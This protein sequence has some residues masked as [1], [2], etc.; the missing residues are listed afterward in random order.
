MTGPT[1]FLDGLVGSLTAVMTPRLRSRTRWSRWAEARRRRAW[2]RAGTARRR[3]SAWPG[4]PCRAGEPRGC[5]PSWR[6]RPR[7]L[8]PR[9]CRCRRGRASARSRPGSWTRSE[10]APS[11][12][13]L[14]FGGLV[15]LDPGVAVGVV[16]A[17]AD[18]AEA[19]VL[20]HAAE[21]RR[22]DLPG[23][24]PVD[25]RH[26]ALITLGLLLEDP[27]VD[28]GA[29]V[30][31]AAVVL[32]R[33]VDQVLERRPH[34]GDVR[35]V[36]DDREG[37]GDGLVALALLQVVDDDVPALPE[38]VVPAGVL[39]LQPVPLVGPDAGHGV[40]PQGRPP[41]PQAELLAVVVLV[42][43]TEEDVPVPRLVEA[44]LLQRAGELVDDPLLH[45][46][47][48]RPLSVLEGHVVVHGQAG[49]DR[50]ELPRPPEGDVD[51]VL[52]LLLLA[53]L[54]HGL[55]DGRADLGVAGLVGLDALDQLGEGEV[56][57]PG[58]VGRQTDELQVRVPRLEGEV[59]HDRRGQG[60]A[61][62]EHVVEGVAGGGG[63]P[64]LGA[65]AD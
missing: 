44:E 5:Q 33:E 18:D 41:R 40:E 32:E 60:I 53:G 25:D 56:A 50:E 54:D 4:S 7:R 31:Q 64:R 49:Q 17:L 61:G 13:R 46:L 24:E 2:R 62:H 42:Q 57:G 48:E 19:H 11:L 45:E 59:G 23:Q 47:L 63:A 6:R 12:P 14:P 15:L 16:A 9:C 3:P 10:T 55:Q 30:V 28:L 22:V 26:V 35:H 65:T 51:E 43:V 37:P 36:A 8:R 58:G 52:G 29:E 20:Q 34:D 21:V 27:A 38:R 1:R 39:L